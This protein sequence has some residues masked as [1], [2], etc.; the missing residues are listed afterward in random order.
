MRLHQGEVGKG[1][2][3]NAGEADA[4]GVEEVEEVLYSAPV[5]RIAGFTEENYWARVYI[6]HWVHDMIQTCGF[7]LQNKVA[8]NWYRETIVYLQ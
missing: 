1:T 6:G 8:L 3:P 7:V 2:V 5:E 4:N